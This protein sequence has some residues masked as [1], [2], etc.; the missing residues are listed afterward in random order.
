MKILLQSLLILTFVSTITLAQKNVGDDAPDF[1]YTSLANQQFKLSEMEGKVVYI[2]FFGA[3][4]PHCRSNGPVT[5]NEI[6]QKFKNEENFVAVGIDTWN[7]S[8]SAVAGFKNVTGISYALL[9]QGQKSLVDYYGNTSSYDRSVV[10][11]ATGK[12]AYKG[13]GFVNSDFKEVNEAINEQLSLATSNENDVDLPGSV[14]LDQNFP[15]PFNPST[16]I[17]YTL[18]KSNEV[19]L[20]VYNMLGSEIVTLENGFKNSG[21]HTVTFD[22]S[23]F[24][25]GI[26]IYRLTTGS[27]SLTKRMTLLK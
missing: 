2:F 12:I 4:C 11:S 17:S 5:E 7:T 19:S 8:A 13:T 9:L 27:I 20:K 1:T 21:E 18:D 25:S 10:I 22:A 3:N 15:N 23:G 24:S 14:F 16:T 6:Y 26:Y